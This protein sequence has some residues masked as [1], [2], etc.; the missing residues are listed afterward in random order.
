MVAVVRQSSPCASPVAARLGVGRAPMAC[1][2][3]V[4]RAFVLGTDGGVEQVPVA[5][6]HLGG[7]VPEDGH[8]RLQRDAGVDQR[9][10]VGVAQLV[11]GD[12]PDAG[13]RRGAV[14]LVAQ[15]VLS[16]AVAV[17]GEQEV[18]GPS[19]ARVRD[20]PSGAAVRR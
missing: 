14:E 12:V 4:Q 3:Q 7:H 9:G 16:E 15:P 1:L 18:R 19:G 10:G 5:Q 8:Q 13:A 20:R 2:G 17:V 11:R 6:A